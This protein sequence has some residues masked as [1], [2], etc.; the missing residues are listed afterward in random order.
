MRVLAFESSCDECSAALIENG[1]VISV[2][3]HTQS[4]H[5]DFGGVVPELAGRSHLEL[6]D[7]L[8]Q[9]ALHDAEAELASIDC[10]AA[11]SGPGLVGSLLIGL[12]YGQGIAQGRDLP[13]R[14]IHHMEAHL[15]SAEIESGPMPLPFLVLL[16]SGGH[17]LL[18]LVRGLRDYEILGSTLDD[19][20][21]EAYDK[22]GKLVGL[23]FP[24]GAEIDRLAT[25]GDPQSY[26]FPVSKRDASLDFSYSG[27]KTAFR[28]QI[29]KMTPQEIENRR[30]DLLASFQFAALASTKS[31]IVSAVQRISPR[32]LVAA[33]G[34]SANSVLREAMIST[35]LAAGVPCYVP[36]MRYC[37]DNAAMVG[38]L[39]W[40]LEQ[41][42]VVDHHE[43]RARPRW[44]ITDLN[45][46][47]ARH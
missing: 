33:G 25:S 20:I 14:Q 10:V 32:A 28:Y 9:Q 19:A 34:V 8:C 4:V 37:A 46:E 23:S 41:E 3:T 43:V 29:Q 24:A 21:G 16:V 11:T 45:K 2:R 44:T 12:H 13:F 47:A 36:A 6:I 30:S 39:A 15:Y 26:S 40:K 38:Y 5:R 27:L 35:A 17:T 31:K 18:V 42:R 7:R 22:V 1:S